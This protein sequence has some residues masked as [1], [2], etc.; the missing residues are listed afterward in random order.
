ME[1]ILDITV[2]TVLQTVSEVLVKVQVK[3]TTQNWD[4]QGVPD[5]KSK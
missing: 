3:D 4:C 5:V 2:Y 1:K